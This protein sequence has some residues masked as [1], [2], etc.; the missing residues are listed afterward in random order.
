MYFGDW[1]WVFSIA[2]VP[3]A[4]LE[5]NALCMVLICVHCPALLES[6][7]S[8]SVIATRWILTKSPRSDGINPLSLNVNLGKS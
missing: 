8:A 1:G 7:V 3:F 5:D 4:F 6:C 2:F